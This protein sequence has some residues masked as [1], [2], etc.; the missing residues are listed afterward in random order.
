VLV[1][2]GEI[3]TTNT[4]LVSSMHGEKIA[5]LN[6]PRS[7][8]TKTEALTLAA[9]LVALADDDPERQTFNE[10]LYAVLGT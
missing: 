6:P 4:C 1:M 5:I 9:W 8:M 2:P 7:P 10:I 3:D